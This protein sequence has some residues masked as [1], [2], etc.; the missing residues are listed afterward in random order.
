M[1][2]ISLFDTVESITDEAVSF[3]IENLKDQLN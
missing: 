2:Q 1:R 3:V